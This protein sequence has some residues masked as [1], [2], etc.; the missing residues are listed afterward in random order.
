LIF[1]LKNKGFQFDQST[2]LGKFFSKQDS[3]GH[4]MIIKNRIDNNEITIVSVERQRQHEHFDMK[5]PNQ[6]GGLSHAEILQIK[7][8]H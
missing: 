8:N 2:Y 3:D 4:G 6:S 1:N 5:I 7:I